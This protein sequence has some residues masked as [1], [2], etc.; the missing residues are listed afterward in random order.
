MIHYIRNFLERILSVGWQE[1][2]LACKQCCSNKSVAIIGQIVTVHCQQKRSSLALLLSGT[3]R[4]ITVDPPN[5]SALLKTELFGIPIVNVNIQ[6]S[7]C[8][9]AVPLIRSQ[10]VALYKCVL[11]D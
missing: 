8:H 10:Y 1:W 2:L 5:F 11:I 3:H 9:Y 6:P 7:L 4:R